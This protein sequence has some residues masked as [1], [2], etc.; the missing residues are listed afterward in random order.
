MTV[1]PDTI[2]AVLRCPWCG[3]ALD[4]HAAGARCATCPEAYPLVGEVLDLRLRR[5]K[6][7][8]L[9]FPIG[10]PP[11]ENDGP[12][13]APLALHPNPAVDFE[14]VVVPTHLSPEFLSHLPRARAARSL[15]LDLGCGNDVHR[16]VCER[17]GFAW[18]GVDYG[19]A[20]AP[21]WGDAQALPFA[22]DTFE[23]VVSVA[24]LEHIRYPMVML[25]EAF[26]VLQ[27]G[28]RLMGTVAFLEPYHQAS[29]YHHSHLGTLNALRFGG[30]D[31]EA[32]APQ[33]HWMVLRAQA[34]MGLFPRMPEPL[35]RAVIAPLQALH[36]LWWRV[37]RLADRRATESAR[38]R[39]TTGAFTF[40]ATKPARPEA[41]TADGSPPLAQATGGADGQ[42]PQVGPR[43]G[44]AQP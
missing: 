23:L 29:H 20:G 24:V 14:G 1:I 17:A 2:W 6:E 40:L 36:R 37:A 5:I 10:E 11:L 18:V 9:R 7:Q 32:V 30:F 31:V 16:E 33:P 19:A 42:A 27:P 15:A 3:G 34:Q 8:T 38:L 41:F 39:H 21:I 25:R 4:R 28:G 44:Q 43:H 12:T 22:D 13:F 35:A 26:R